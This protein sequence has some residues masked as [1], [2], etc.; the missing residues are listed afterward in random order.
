MGWPR[1]AEVPP[2]QEPEVVVIEKK[3][4]PIGEGVEKQSAEESEIRLK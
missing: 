4:E 3:E 2:V 1:G